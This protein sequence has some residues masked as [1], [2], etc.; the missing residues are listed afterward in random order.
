VLLL[1]Q[2]TTARFG[3]ISNNLYYATLIGG[4]AKLITLNN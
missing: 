1:L 3:D 2:G 4:V